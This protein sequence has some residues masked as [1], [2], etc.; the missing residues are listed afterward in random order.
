MNVLVDCDVLLDVMLGREPW[1]DASMQ[2]LEYCE[3]SR[4]PTYAAWHTFSNVYYYA[5]KQEGAVSARSYIRD[6]LRFIQ[7]AP[8]G[9][10]DMIFALEQPV[11]DLEDAMQV[12]AAVACRAS[13]IVTRNVRHFRKSPIPAITPAKFLAQAAK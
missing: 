8:V 11:L 7:V 10:G 4:T 2:F 9:T 13:C 1:A 6:L 12:A 5:T 3:F